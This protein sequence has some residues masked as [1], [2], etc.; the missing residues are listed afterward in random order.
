MIEAVGDEFLAAISL[1]AHHYLKE[2]GQMLDSG[3]YDA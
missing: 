2:D 3:Y 1:V